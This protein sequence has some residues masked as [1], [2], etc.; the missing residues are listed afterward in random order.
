MARRRTRKERRPRRFSRRNPLAE[1]FEDTPYNDST[2]AVWGG[3]TLSTG[4]WLRHPSRKAL[5]EFA[6]VQDAKTKHDVSPLNS[7]GGWAHTL[8]PPEGM[9]S[10][11]EAAKDNLRRLKI[12]LKQQGIDLDELQE[13]NPERARQ[14]LEISLYERYFDPAKG[15]MVDR[16]S[17][18]PR[19]FPA[20]PEVID[21]L[22]EIGNQQNFWMLPSEGPLT[23]FEAYNTFGAPE[24]PTRKK[25]QKLQKKKRKAIQERRMEDGPLRLHRWARK[26]PWEGEKQ[27]WTLLQTEE[28]YKDIGDRFG[29]CVWWNHWFNNPEADRI[30]YRKDPEWGTETIARYHYDPFEEDPPY[31][32]ELAVHFGH[33]TTWVLSPG[34][35]T[36][37]HGDLEYVVAPHSGPAQQKRTQAMRREIRNWLRNPGIYP[38]GHL[39]LEEIYGPR[40]TNWVSYLDEVMA[41]DDRGRATQ[42]EDEWL[43]RILVGASE[44][45][46]KHGGIKNIR[47]QYPGTVESSRHS[48][49]YQSVRLDEIIERAARVLAP[50]AGSDFEVTKPGWGP[51]FD[52]ILT[53]VDRAY[54]KEKEA[55]EAFGAAMNKQLKRRSRGRIDPQGDLA[56]PNPRRKKMAP[57]RRKT[58]RRRRARRNP[59]MS[60]GV[61]YQDIL[62]HLRALQWVYWTTHWQVSGDT[63]YG[64]HLLLNRLYAGRGGGPKINDQIDDLG[65]RMVAYFGAESVNPALINRKVHEVLLW[66]HGEWMYMPTAP[67][68]EEGTFGQ[69]YSLEVRLQGAIRRAWEA[70][71]KSGTYMS[72]GLDDY[73]MSLANERD[74]AIYLLG[75][76]LGGKKPLAGPSARK[77]PNDPAFT[78]EVRIKGPNDPIY[79]YKTSLP[80]P[81]DVI[82]E[83]EENTNLTVNREPLRTY[84]RRGV[85]VQRVY[86]TNDPWVRLILND[87]GWAAEVDAAYPPDRFGTRR[88]RKNPRRKLPRRDS[89]GRFVKSRRS[90]TRK[91]RK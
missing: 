22:I 15:E 62:V 86:A 8:P 67:G 82:R 45:I 25:L 72:L 57:R 27:G 2:W 43:D 9:K 30:Y 63:F 7:I 35:H 49:D 80:T 20:G 52:K 73:L 91:N 48:R 1:G 59:L 70:N 37:S 38:A 81:D 55:A 23:V 68:L 36:E 85:L 83:V 29:N 79:V 54:R 65:E 3:P 76:R 47:V 88:A 41:R 60:D 19:S 78:Y 71:Q 17:P 26:H 13:R 53:P 89:K 18:R 16:V 74:T 61:L 34:P 5:L 77:N 33:P 84:R 28:E 56:W 69:L 51:G 31:L 40:R 6:R 46:K 58:T 12:S 64:D 44:I 24:K 66:D 32:E 4:A 14:F 11:P 42:E 50:R 39:L 21:R 90:S 87:A 10:G 75:R